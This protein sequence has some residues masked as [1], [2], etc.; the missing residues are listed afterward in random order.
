MVNHETGAIKINL[1]L[2]SNITRRAHGKCV[3][4]TLM[5]SGNGEGSFVFGTY[6]NVYFSGLGVTK[7]STIEK[8][9]AIG[10]YQVGAFRPLDDEGFFGQ[11]VLHLGEGMPETGHVG[12]ADS[13]AQFRIHGKTITCCMG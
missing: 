4:A 5:L 3:G 10:V 9:V 7:V 12:A 13:R 11:V 8:T 6:N 2:L 1:K